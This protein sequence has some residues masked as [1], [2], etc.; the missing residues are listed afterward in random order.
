MEVVQTLLVQKTE[1]GVNHTVVW[2]P[3]DPRVKR[4]SIISLKDEPERGKWE[5]AKLFH[6]QSLSDI[7]RGWGLDLPKSQRTER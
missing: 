7:Q 6:R 1:T 3:V 4:G 2:L 5:V